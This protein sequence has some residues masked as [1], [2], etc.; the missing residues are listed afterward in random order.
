MQ[1]IAIEILGEKSAEGKQL[2][3]SAYLNPEQV[4]MWASARKGVSVVTL[5]NGAAIMV[6]MS[7]EKFAAAWSEAMYDEGEIDDDEDDEDEED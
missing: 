3:N 6:K 2:T 4:V 1:A 5:L 7:A